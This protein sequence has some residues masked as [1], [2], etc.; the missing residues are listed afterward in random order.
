MLQYT[1]LHFNEESFALNDVYKEASWYESGCDFG[2]ITNPF[3]AERDNGTSV[4]EGRD[5]SP[6]SVTLFLVKENMAFCRGEK[7]KFISLSKTC[8]YGLECGSHYKY[9]YLNP[10]Y[11]FDS[12]DESQ[13]MNVLEAMKAYRGWISKLSTSSDISLP[14]GV[15]KLIWEYWKNGPPPYLFV[16]KGDLL[17]L[18]RYKEEVIDPACPELVSTITREHMVLGRPKR[19]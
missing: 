15:V 16:E 13:R 11:Q 3:T 6:D 9:G 7:Q 5:D 8:N 4:A 12:N 1:F 2:L 14:E 19:D 10:P 17:L 18:A